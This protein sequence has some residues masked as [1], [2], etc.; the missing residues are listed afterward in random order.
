M[1]DCFG[2]HCEERR[3][4]QARKV[5]A[6]L[7]RARYS[8]VAGTDAAAKFC[9]KEVDP[10]INE[11]TMM[12]VRNAAIVISVMGLLS[13]P[14]FAQSAQDSNTYPG[15]VP[16]TPQ[17]QNQSG[18]TSTDQTGATGS[19]NQAAPSSKAKSTGSSGYDTEGGANKEMPEGS[20]NDPSGPGPNDQ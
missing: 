9:Y 10:P 15:S 20:G 16:N 17:S 7:S 12:I 6:P 8:D 5:T 18:Q 4:G 19:V 3:N 14:V 1:Q 11:G 2:P 13:G